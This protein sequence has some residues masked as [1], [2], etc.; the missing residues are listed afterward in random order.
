MIFNFD[1]SDKGFDSIFG[2]NL[3][4]DIWSSRLPN[5]S[6]VDSFGF[7]PQLKKEFFDQKSNGMS[8]IGKLC[9]QNN[10]SSIR[11]AIGGIASTL[12]YLSSEFDNINNTFEVP[13]NKITLK[14]QSALAILD[15]ASD[16]YK[17]GLN[18]MGAIPVVGWILGIIVKVAELVSNI[19]KTV[20]ENNASDAKNKLITQYAIP[21]AAFSK[22]AD[23]ALTRI[24]MDHIQAGDMN[25]LFAPRYIYEDFDDFNVIRE[26]NEAPDNILTRAFNITSKKSG[27]IG[28]IPGTLEI[29]SAIRLLTKPPGSGGAGISDV[30][31]F[32]PTVR[33]LCI[34]LFEQIQKPSTA[35]FSIT[36]DLLATAWETNIYNML[37][38]SELSLIKGWSGFQ[39]GEIDTDKF[40][41][42]AEVSG[43]LDCKK[44]KYND[45]IKI[46]ITTDPFGHF[47]RFRDFISD[48][49]FNGKYKEKKLITK[50][51]QLE[52]NSKNIKVKESIPSL[53]LKNIRETQYAV[54]NSL[55]CCYVSDDTQ[56][57]A[58]VN[59]SKLNTLWNKNL[60]AVLGSST[61]WKKLRYLDIPEGEFKNEIFLK[62][63]KAGFKDFENRKGAIDNKVSNVKSSGSI[64]GDL[65]PPK[66]FMPVGISGDLKM[67]NKTSSKSESKLV[68]VMAAAAIGGLFLMNK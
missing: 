30:G 44:S 24:C 14:I 56:F 48:K 35:L 59:D 28:F 6:L 11:T 16:S 38:Y 17:D 32:Y 67:K 50:L 57:A 46:P 40:L 63:K 41:C 39:T 43:Q 60:S 52:F 22:D 54:M 15:T 4:M 8:Y 36:P 13:I 7:D 51:D 61:E 5:P 25:Y 64:F 68:G 31:D 49:F 18:A 23:E 58:V 66:P 3:N 21:L 42:S 47:N 33:N 9:F 29:N 37:K 27:G 19:I 65:K 26:K 10:V 20:Q 2:G 62:A 45:Y 34:S 12:G 55:N 53:A 1:K